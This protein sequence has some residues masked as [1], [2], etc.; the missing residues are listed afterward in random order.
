MRF[1]KW[2]YFGS[3]ALITGY[4][5][6]SLFYYSYLMILHM[7]EAGYWFNFTDKSIFNRALPNAQILNHS[8]SVYLAKLSLEW[9]GNNGIGYRFP[10]ILFGTL[11]VVLVYLFVKQE[12]GRA[13]LGVMAA[14]L[15]MLLPWF[16]HNSHEL[17]GYPPLMFFCILSF[18]SLIGLI[19]KRNPTWYWIFLFFSFLGCYLANIGAIVF[20][21]VFMAT[22]WIIK[23][24]KIWWP[25]SDNFRAFQ[26]ISFK[27]LLIFS[28]IVTPIFSYLI[29]VYDAHWV[30]TVYDPKSEFAKSINYTLGLDIF[31]TYLGYIYL[32][33]PESVLYKYPFPVYIISLICCLYGLFHYIREKRGLSFFIVVLY[34]S[35]LIFNAL[36]GRQIQT[37]AVVYF[38]PFIVMF[39]AY[40]IVKVGENI[41]SKYFWNISKKDF[42]YTGTS[43][44]LLTYLLFF[45]IGKH[46]QFDPKSGNPYEKAKE[47]LE[48]K[49]GLNDIIISSLRETLGG[50]YFGDIIR[51]KTKNIYKSQS[52]NAVYYLTSNKSDKFITLTN[53]FGGQKKFF[54]LNQFEKVAEFKNNAMPGRS[55][56]VIVYKARI[57]KF[58]PMKLN[59]V[60]LND[61]NYFGEYG[62]CEKNIEKQG[63][64]LSCGGS[65]MVCAGNYLKLNPLKYQHLILHT[66]NDSA[67]GVISS[68]TLEP[69]QSKKLK[70]K[71]VDF[72]SNAYRINSMVDTKENLDRFNENVSIFSPIIQSKGT[73]EDYQ[74][75]LSGR[76]FQNNSLIKGISVLNFSF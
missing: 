20:I 22:L 38:L 4:F 62:K 46:S 56:R 67:A 58:V 61:V 42:I 23:I 76:M 32:D 8:I 43:I 73:S 28:C 30:L 31:S 63:M 48:T 74:L 10:V 19:T 37:R 45:S 51:Q 71:P 39:Q 11:D 25:N 52:L 29:F 6:I 9:F 49:S 15:L 50:F 5:L 60:Q 21:F 16:L 1:P 40:G 44:A 65:K 64:R 57:L 36:I 12:M 7:D 3:V 14:A 18:F 72:F 54:N 34:F 70:K 53:Y 41:A 24:W 2:I 66:I 27:P 17:R 75:C 33:D 13:F 26:P 47:Y 35:T 68:V 55:A 69:I 59:A